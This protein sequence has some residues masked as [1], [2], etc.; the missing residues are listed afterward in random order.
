MSKYSVSLPSETSILGEGS[1]LA[2]VSVWCVSPMRQHS[3]GEVSKL[4][5]V[6]AWW[7]S[8][9][10]HHSQQKSDNLPG[11]CSMTTLRK[12][13]QLAWVLAQGPLSGMSG[14][15]SIT[16]LIT[17]LVGVRW[18]AWVLAQWPLFGKSDNM[19]GCVFNKSSWWD[20]TFSYLSIQ[21]KPD[22]IFGRPVGPKEGSGSREGVYSISIA[23][24]KSIS[25]WIVF[26]NTQTFMMA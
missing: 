21:G 22:N 2:Q 4:A 3:L 7:D 9:M 12:V 16:C 13:K 23:I 18:L 26:P 11:I 19:P 10:R 14:N 5:W 6:H 25:C 8:P 24:F 17:T 20:T 1:Q 15:L